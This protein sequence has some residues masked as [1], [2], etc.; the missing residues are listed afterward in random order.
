MATST[1]RT[2]RPYPDE[3]GGYRPRIVVKFHDYVDL[4]Y[5]DGVEEYIQQRKLGPWESLAA[6]Y[7]GL[8]LTRLYQTISGDQINEL[9]DRARE[10]D[11][12]YRPP[13]LLTYFAID[14]PPE[15]DPEALAKELSSWRTVQE[16]YV[17]GGPTPPPAVNA[18]DDPR[19]VNQ[20]YLDPAPAG[21]DAEWAWTIAGGDGTGVDFV[22][23]ERGWTLNH[24]DLL[25]AGI[26]LISGVNKDYFGHGTAVL[27]EVAAVD[28]ALGNVGVATAGGA[29]VVSQWR[30]ATTYNTEEAILSAVSVLDFG[31][32]LLLEAQTSVAGWPGYLPV[33]VETA[34]Y[35]AIRL[36]TALGIA[37]VEAAGNGSTDLDTF[38]DAGGNQI[39]N[40]GSAAFRDSGAIMVGAASS[41]AP[42]GPMWFTNFGSRIDCYAWG[43]NVDTT[44]DGWTGNLTTTYTAIFGGTSSAS[45]IVA[46]AAM[47]VQGLADASLLFRFSPRQL[48]NILASPA[49]GTQSSDPPNDRIGVMPDLKTISGPAVLNI[50][51]DIYLRDFVG[52]DG[53]PHSGAISASP[54]VILRQTAEPTPQVAFG[55]GSGT[56]N[57]DMLGFEA[58]AGQDN[59]LYVRVR[60]RGGSAA[61]NVV[62]T[63]YW[64]PPATLVTPN[65]WTLVDSVTIPSVAT[66]NQL[67]VSDAIV[68]PSAAIPATGH[69][70]FVALIGTANDPAPGLADFLN[71]NNFQT[72]IRAN[73]NVTWRNFN[74]VNNVPPADA[75]PPGFIALPFIAPGAPDAAR[76]MRLEI[77]GRLPVG[78]RLMLEAPLYMLDGIEERAPFVD[79]DQKRGLGVLPVSARGRFDLGEMLF[80]AESKS[81]LRLLVEVPEKFREEEYDV[82]ARQLFE[83]EEVGRITWRLAPPRREEPRDE[84]ERETAERKV[85]APE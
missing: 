3:G 63:V 5:E 22:D 32:V 18:T 29:R 36:G 37:I 6:D 33:E 39:L 13:N 27:G 71:W 8:T 79:V 25:G 21:I 61:A 17:E 58:E 30:T 53:D 70:C 20:G 43:E 83:G 50:V 28:N 14:C 9:V 46:G 81:E 35:D 67:T 68:W 78:A 34:V 51:P 10:R 2:R 1:G 40:R 38:T 72:F 66:G 52:D 11:R 44:G 55:Q 26:T 77:V 85:G 74:V 49:N 31:D 69:Y 24:E 42:H 54:D 41:V 64:A 65:L 4:P 57:N 84:Y 47:A 59:Y 19:S 76:R 12:T 16:A 75:S 82:Y 73:N 48:R 7:P 80:P 45:P 23:L 60:N 56:E 62:A 15:A